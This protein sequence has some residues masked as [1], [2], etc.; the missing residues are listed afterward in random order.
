MTLFDAYVMVDWSSEA[1]PK[2]GKDSIWIAVF[3]RGP[4]GL[5][6]K[7][8]V[9]ATTRHNAVKIILRKLTEFI[10]R[11]RNTLLGFDFAFAYPTGFAKALDPRKPDWLGVWFRL[12]RLIEDGEDNDNN[13]YEVAEQLNR[14]LTA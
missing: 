10:S 1:R 12:S 8:L 4:A 13:R 3:E 7:L 11:G 14:A 2:K 5:A 9:N 6:E